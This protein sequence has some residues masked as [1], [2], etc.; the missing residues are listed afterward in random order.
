MSG[1]LNSNLVRRVNRSRLFHA[2]RERPGLSQRELSESTGLDPSTVSNIIRELKAERL[3]VGTRR[4]APE[5]LTG[6]PEIDLRLSED[7]GVFVGIQLDMRFQTLVLTTMSGRQLDQLKLDSSTDLDEAIDITV[8]AVN[9]MLARHGQASTPLLGVGVG[10]A[11]LVTDEGHLIVN[12]YQRHKWEDVDLRGQL[13]ARLPGP[14]RVGNDATA[15][16]LAEKLFGCCRPLRNFV[17][18]NGY[19]GIGGGLY[20]DGKTFLGA[21]GLAGEVGHIKVVQGGRACGCGGRGC[22]A[23]Y[24]SITSL[25]RILRERGIDVRDANGIIDLADAGESAVLEA[26]EHAGTLLGRVFATLVN[27]AHPEAIVISGDLAKLVRYLLPPALRALEAEAFHEL[28]LPEQLLISPLEGLAVPL[29][30][31]GLAMEEFLSVPSWLVPGSF[32]LTERDVGGEPPAGRP[33][34]SGAARAQ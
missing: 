25:V 10:V 22:L 28:R 21:G 19:A 23:A 1:R 11:G 16:A 17:V 2:L 8:E 29:G 31:V 3:V 20:L 18:V 32:Q 30:G 14:V 5:R 33:V 34:V 7:A 24:A 15:A 9:T 27:V 12:A 4:Q 13:S 26:L 6:R